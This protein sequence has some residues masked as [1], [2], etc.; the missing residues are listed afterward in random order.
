MA[1]GFVYILIGLR[2]VLEA[3]G[4]RESNPFES[5]VDTVSG[6]FLA[7]FEG[8]FPSARQ[9]SMTL[10]FSYVAA[11]MVYALLHFVVRRMVVNIV[12]RRQFI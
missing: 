10:V 7:P 9:G 8:L 1:F 2:I 4:A 5:F 11:L 3:L 12:R 6:P